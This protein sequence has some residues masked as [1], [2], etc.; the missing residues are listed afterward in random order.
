[1]KQ[2]NESEG[3]HGVFFIHG[4]DMD[5]QFKRAAASIKKDIVVQAS[6]KQN[7]AL[8]AVNPTSINTIR[9]MT[10]LRQDG[11]RICSAILRMGVNGSRVDSISQ[12][13]ICCGVDADGRLK[14]VAYNYKGE[15]FDIHP[16]TG[17]HFSDVVIP[18]FDK[19]IQM[20]TMVT[21]THPYIPDFRL[22]SWDV[23][24]DEDGIPMLVEANLC[25]GELN[26]H[27]LCNGPI[28]GDNT[29][30]VLDEVFHR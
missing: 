26:L 30:L 25:Y 10:L 7:A 21:E 29:Q 5:E 28:F 22:V 20:V 3:G 15:S 4:A 12:G 9:V 8:S 1:M 2:A 19:I 23:A 13:G 16:T 17:V 27:Q 24:M 6:I 18:N 14:P 11:V